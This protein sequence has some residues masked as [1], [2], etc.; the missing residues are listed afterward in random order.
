MSTRR[1]IL[2]ACL[3]I[4]TACDSETDPGAPPTIESFTL[5]QADVPV[6]VGTTL[7]GTLAFTDPD[8]DV[9]D[10]ELVVTDPAGADTAVSTPVQGADGLDAGSVSVAIQFAAPT[11]GDYFISATLHDAEGNASEPFVVMFS[12]S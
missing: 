4:S 8:G 7:T 9:A 6:G 2:L 3:L 11:P 5:G 12:A 1:A 10:A